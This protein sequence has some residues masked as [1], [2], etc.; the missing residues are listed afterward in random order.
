METMQKKKKRHHCIND[1][2]ISEAVTTNLKIRNL[3]GIRSL[4]MHDNIDTYFSLD[5]DT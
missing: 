4:V 1:N 5:L 3:Y 2:D